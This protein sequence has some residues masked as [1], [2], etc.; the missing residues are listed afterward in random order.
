MTEPHPALTPADL[1]A[2]APARLPS[3]RRLRY[4]GDQMGIAL[5]RFAPAGRALVARLYTSLGELL[6][7]LGPGQGS[8]EAALAALPARCAAL[9]W[10]ELLREL[11]GLSLAAGDDDA[12]ARQVLHDLKGGA[13]Q[14]LAAYIQL[15]AR[16]LVSAA[17]LN[18]MFFLARDQLK[19]MRSCV[20]GL[21]AAAAA[22]DSAYRL[23]SVELLRE[24]W[25]SAEHRVG[26]GPVEVRV[27]T[28]FRGDIAEGCLEFAAL[29]RVLYNLINNAARHSADGAV[30]LWIAPVGAGPDSLRFVVA[31]LVTP[32]QRRVLAARFP[33]G[34][35]ELFEGGF[36]TGGVGLGMR[37]CADFVCNAYGVPAVAQALAEGH[38]GARMIGERFVAWVHWPLAGE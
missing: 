30:D 18:R 11:R 13:L 21:D 17:Q 37:I 12:L 34:L 8:P 27:H 7:L 5:E 33:A 32:E 35:G 2:L 6:E 4:S 22:R 25:A 28:A 36:T 38:L 16:G 20:G 15:A 1:A 24:K 9:G 31:N 26:A 29:D 14:A 19:I 3:Y 10:D 23:H